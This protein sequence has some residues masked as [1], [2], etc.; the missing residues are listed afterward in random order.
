MRPELWL[1]HH[2]DAPLVRQ[3]RD[4]LDRFGSLP[5]PA[6]TDHRLS[7]AAESIWHQS[8]GVHAMIAQ[9]VEHANGSS[10]IVAYRTFGREIDSLLEKRLSG[11]QRGC[12]RGATRQNR[13]S[14]HST[15]LSETELHCQLYLPH[16]RIV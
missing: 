1:E 2:L 7:L 10:R 13:E 8:Y 15:G 11:I 16:R 14:L 4:C 9:L 3:R 5:S 6:E 12:E